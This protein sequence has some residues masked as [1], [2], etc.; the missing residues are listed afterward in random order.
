MKVAISL[1][2]QLF[3]EA[4][5]FA[6]RS[7]RSL[8]RLCSEAVAEFL[9]RHAPDQVSESINRATG[10]PDSRTE[11]EFAV[12]ASRRMLRKEKW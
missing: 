2:D 8:S 11:A 3:A 5:R 1:P 7:G 12:A 4:E 10:L 6:G 9:A